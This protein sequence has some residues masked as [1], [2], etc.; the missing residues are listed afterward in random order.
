MDPENENKTPIFDE[1]EDE[2]DVYSEESNTTDIIERLGKSSTIDEDDDMES[3][4]DVED[5]DIDEEKDDDDEE[6]DEDADED[7]S[8][9]DFSED[10]DDDDEDEE[11]V[12]DETKQKTKKS[13]NPKMKKTELSMTEQES[14][15]ESD[16]EDYL[17]KLDENVR[18]NII[19]DHHP[20]MIQHNDEEVET[21]C[22]IVR[23]ADGIIID[24]LHK[25]LPFVTKYEKARILGERAKQINSGA[26]P[27]IKVEK[28]LIDG[29]LIAMKEF[30]EKKIPFIVRRPLPNGASEY[31]K[32]SD[33]QILE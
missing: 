21:L 29:Y 26:K 10:E 15:D 20:E 4:A 24:P 28:H 16:D 32:L 1:S 30:E 7:D 3:D 33:L 13:K 8:E 9:N 17:Q 23:D 31:W 5:A 27:F 11:M 6:K 22:K 14:D 19:G 25:T 18:S 2:D 12:E